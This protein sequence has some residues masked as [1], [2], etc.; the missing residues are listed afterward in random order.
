MIGETHIKI[1]KWFEQTWIPYGNKVCILE[2]FPGVG[3]TY[4]SQKIAQSFNGTSV[5]ITATEASKESMEEVIF[6][7]A[8]EL[9]IQGNNKLV[10]AINAEKNLRKTLTLILQE[11]ILIIIDE[12]QEILGANE[13]ILAKDWRL[14]LKGLTSRPSTRGKLLLLT[15]RTVKHTKWAEHADVKILKGFNI[16][17]GELYLSSLL[18]ESNREGEISPEQ[19]EGIIRLLGGNPRAIKLLT[20]SL[21]F[22]SLED[23]IKITEESWEYKGRYF[24]PELVEQLEIRLLK[25]ILNHISD[26][27]ESILRNISVLR[28]PFKKEVFGLFLEGKYLQN[29]FKKRVIE[30]FLMEQY[31]GWFKLN[32]IVREVELNKLYD[33][34]PS[35]FKAHKSVSRYYTRHFHGKNIVLKIGSLG[36][37][38]NE[39]KFHLSFLENGEELDNITYLFTNYIKKTISGTSPV[40]KTPQALNERIAVLSSLLQSPGPKGLEY[41]LT[42]LYSIRRKN[43]DIL[44]AIVHGKRSLS[45]NTPE[46]WILTSKVL[47]QANK[48]EEAIDLLKDGIKQV[49]ADR[50]VF[51]IYQACAQLL[52][53][54]NRIEEAIALLKVGIKEIAI[55]KGLVHIYQVCAHLLSQTNRNEEAI[56]MLKEGIKKIPA[57]RNV[58]SI[59]QTCAQLM[60]LENRNKEAIDLLK[61]GIEKIAIDKG[62]VN[63]YQTCAQL[64]S[65][66]NRN[67]EAIDLLK[68][69]I[70][71]IPANQSAFVIYQTCAQLLSLEN[72]HEEAIEL[73]KVGITKIPADR[74]VFSIYQACAELLSKVNRNEEAIDLLK[75]G[76]KKIATDKGLVHIYQACAEL[77]SRTNRNKEAIDLLKVGIDKIPADKG[78]VDLYQACAQ[79][80]SLENRNEEA[81][82]LLKVGID[83]IPM[84]KGLVD[85]YQACA[86]LLGRE[87]RNEEAIDLLKVGINK[88]PADK[89]LV[90]IYQAYAE[91]LSQLNR[92]QEAIDLLK[93]GIKKIPDN[94]GGRKLFENCV[95]YLLKEKNEHGLVQMKNNISNS[96]NPQLY[97]VDFF[98]S[99]LAN[100]WEKTIEI[101]SKCKIEFPS[102]S[103]IFIQ[104]AFVHLYLNEPKK[105]VEIFESLKGKIRHYEGS[106]ISWLKSCIYLQLEQ[107]EMAN[108]FLSTYYGYQTNFQSEELQVE[109]YN[110]WRNKNSS[111]NMVNHHFPL[112]LPMFSN[113][114]EPGHTASDLTDNPATSALTNEKKSPQEILQQKIKRSS[115]DVFLCHNS[116]N[117]KTIKRIGN[118]LKEF[119]LLPWLDEWEIVPGR[120]WQEALENQI[121]NIKSVA[122]FI[123]PEGIGP[124]QHSEMNAFLRKFH[125]QRTPIIPVILPTCQNTPELPVFLEGFHWVDFRKESPNP[126]HQL[127]WGITGTK[128]EIL[129]STFPDSPIVKINN[130]SL[131]E[132]IKKVIQ[133]EIL[134]LRNQVL[135]KADEET[136]K[137]INKL[138]E[139]QLSITGILIKSIEE[140]KIDQSDLNELLDG[141]REL[142]SNPPDN[143]E[144]NQAL[145]KVTPIIDDTKFGVDHKLRLTIPL[146]PAILSYHGEYK[147]SSGLNFSELIYRIAKKVHPKLK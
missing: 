128:P 13:E 86:Q 64:L 60:S 25:N 3:K 126:Y 57:D 71:K 140:S 11:P 6:D 110:I 120:P 69:G 39:A 66:E 40:P 20:S 73:L 94:K 21:T 51:A 28:K 127:L 50:N 42:K 102:Y 91:S 79:L 99:L 18:K 133:D 23:L 63:I 17:D 139:T 15:N 143:D 118:Q 137:V 115:F 38:F 103:Q 100:E 33:N 146:I 113:L 101:A 14:F 109:L 145:E 84:D 81:I 43:D 142:K 62:L 19:K 87:N 67:K 16:K 22:N 122:V 130:Q 144:I 112:L 106:P 2:G 83:K 55:D 65:L 111:K 85:L 27:D 53:Q 104:E 59:Y 147:L 93:V 95:L 61:D 54:E 141:I 129:F 98:I 68:D 135:T 37:Y 124:W 114:L 70:E 96:S 125:Q 90:H 92:N 31:Q 36:A 52:R 10:D 75:E 89:G 48:N 35:L 97:F 119:G 105:A 47:S 12:F 8:Y 77:L 29:Q 1:F 76:I 26:E 46:G 56:A 34:Q 58:Y 49:P 78:L 136:S 88:I 116:Q 9:D 123:G 121:K 41:H 132:D 117:K 82:D 138:N 134:I 44:K 24:S 30:L 108:E 4:L 107:Q 32:P 74:N 80:L 5:F 45:P 7:L 72:R 131:I